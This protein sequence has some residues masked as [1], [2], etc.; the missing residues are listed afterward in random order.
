MCTLCNYPN[1]PL[2]YLNTHKVKNSCTLHI[3]I[4]TLV[5]SNK[6]HPFSRQNT[7]HLVNLT[8]IMCCYSYKVKKNMGK[9]R[10]FH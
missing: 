5:S 9:K 6:Y 1:K 4:F 2:Q 10:C 7:N 8:L 3:K